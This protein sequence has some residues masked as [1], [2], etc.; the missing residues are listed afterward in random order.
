MSSGY[1]V[2]YKRHMLVQHSKFV[3]GCV[4]LDSWYSGTLM[5]RLLKTK[6]LLPVS[7]CQSLAELMLLYLDIAALAGP[8]AVWNLEITVEVH[9]QVVSLVGNDLPGTLHIGWEVLG[10]VWRLDCPCFSM[11]HP[12]AAWPK[13]KTCA[14]V[15]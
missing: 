14:C 7:L 10:I 13:T 15:K 12:S 4:R 5:L 2:S 6:P 8:S 9:L 11:D 3:A 1:T